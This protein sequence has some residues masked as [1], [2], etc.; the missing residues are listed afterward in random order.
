VGSLYRE[1]CI[2]ERNCSKSAGWQSAAASTSIR[3]F[4]DVYGGGSTASERIGW[5][6]AVEGDAVGDDRDAQIALIPGSR[7]IVF[8]A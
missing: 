1:F 3:G 7:A 5:L 4:L 6:A 8:G 2:S